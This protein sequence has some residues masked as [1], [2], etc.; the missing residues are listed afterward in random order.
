[1]MLWLLACTT[2]PALTL[3]GDSSAGAT[4]W[5]AD[6]ALCHGNEAEGTPRGPALDGEDAEAFVDVVR[7]G[8]GDMP[9]FDLTDQELADLLAWLP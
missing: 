9:A 3:T 5:A 4:L 7:F 6:C 2:D 8:R 1:M